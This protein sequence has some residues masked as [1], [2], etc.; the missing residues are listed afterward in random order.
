MDNNTTNPWG[1]ELSDS[2]ERSSEKS[3]NSE[4]VIEP[5]YYQVSLLK[6]ALML[7]ASFG[8]YEIFWFYRHWLSAKRKFN[9]KIQPALRGIFFIFFTH[10]LFRI[11]SDH[12]KHLK[13]S[14]RWNSSF[15]ATMFIIIV[16][17]D[18]IWDGLGNI[19]TKDSAWYS[20]AILLIGLSSIPL[21]IVQKTA[22]TLNGD[23]DCNISGK[24]RP[25]NFLLIIPGILLWL[26]V[27]IGLS[28]LIN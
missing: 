5:S 27:I 26:L 1:T 9:L 16:I 8:L 11:I 6:L 17:V 14:I 4:S 25:L 23:P 12:A 15:L 10:E 18:R 13:I 7:F 21:L 24:L 2:P 20:I 22:N 19:T 28:D 3:N